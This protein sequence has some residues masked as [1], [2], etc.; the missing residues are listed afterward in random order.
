M[1][2][3]APKRPEQLLRGEQDGAAGS[4]ASRTRWS[5][6]ATTTGRSG[7]N[8]STRAITTSSASTPASVKCTRTDRLTVPGGGPPART[9]SN[10]TNGSTPVRACSSSKAEIRRPRWSSIGR[11][12]QA[13]I[14]TL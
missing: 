9:P 14:E 7:G 5:L 4:G 13:A 8:S 1:K 3:S 2:P 11:S 6:E 10:T 12:G